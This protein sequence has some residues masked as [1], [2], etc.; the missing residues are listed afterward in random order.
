MFYLTAV[1]KALST[2]IQ[3]HEMLKSLVYNF[4]LRNSVTRVIPLRRYSDDKKSELNVID[5]Q[6]FNSSDIKKG[7]N[8]E[9]SKSEDQKT[10]DILDTEGENFIDEAY[11]RGEIP[12]QHF[13][14]I[15]KDTKQESPVSDGLNF[16]DE[17]FF[18]DDFTEQNF[19]SHE[20][21]QDSG[22]KTKDLSNQ[23]L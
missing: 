3:I 4:A 1:T 2:D 6:Y 23:D 18:G 19:S 12:L 7:D 11:F 17:A 5:Q 20:F 9:H 8:F 15:V 10:V 14:D 21:F 13:Q 16:F 22:D